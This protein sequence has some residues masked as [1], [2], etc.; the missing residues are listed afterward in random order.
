MIRKKTGYM[1]VDMK[2]YSPARINRGRKWQQQIGLPLTLNHW[3]LI[4]KFMVNSLFKLQKTVFNVLTT[5]DVAYYVSCGVLYK[6]LIAESPFKAKPT[7]GKSFPAFPAGNRFFDLQWQQACRYRLI[8]EI[9]VLLRIFLN[10]GRKL[11]PAIDAIAASLC[12]L[13]DDW[14]ASIS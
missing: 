13:S 10:C 4:Y 9:G 11:I 6:Q 14:L 12:P 5:Y 2:R 7:K 8:A 3:Y 1:D